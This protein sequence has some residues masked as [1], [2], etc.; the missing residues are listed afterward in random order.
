MRAHSLE[1]HAKE[2]H[3]RLN[4]R[5]FADGLNSVIVCLLFGFDFGENATDRF[6]PEKN[7]DSELE[8]VQK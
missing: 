7:S 8:K 4:G 2:C 1:H 5:E 6:L 3:L